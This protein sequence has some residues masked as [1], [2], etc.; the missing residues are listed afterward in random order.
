VKLVMA[1]TKPICIVFK[2]LFLDMCHPIIFL[3]L[4]L[5]SLIVFLQCLAYCIQAIDGVDH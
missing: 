3:T 2:S 4:V 5:V 1:F